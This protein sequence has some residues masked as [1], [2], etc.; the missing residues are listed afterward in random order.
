MDREFIE[1]EESIAES[2]RA[3]TVRFDRSSITIDDV[4]GIKILGTQEQLTE[5]ENA[6]RSDP[7]I[8]VGE[9]ENF[10]G[11]Y[12]AASLILDIPW[13][14]EAGVPKVPGSNWEKYV[15]PG[16]FRPLNSKRGS[17]PSWKIR[18]RESKSS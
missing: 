11:S 3:G 10:Y 15:Q 13:D 9:R 16:H 14:R 8:L 1:A 18:R 5:I 12:E 2:F 6:L 4:G 7:S 17:N